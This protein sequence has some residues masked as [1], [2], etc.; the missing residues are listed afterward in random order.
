MRISKLASL[1]LISLAVVSQSSSAQRRAGRPVA[2]T[3]STLFEI[4]PYAGY[5]VFGDFLSGPLGT[6]LKNAPAPV[7]GAQLG[8]KIAP[9]LSMIGN[10]AASTS[11]IRIG[12]PF[13][14]GIDVAHSS[15]VLYDAGL[16]LDIPMT[17]AYGYTFAPFV[18]GGVG[19]MHYDITQ[20]LVSTSA[21]NLAG[22]IG[23]GADV[24]IGRGVGLRLMAKDYIGKFNF[25]DATSFDFNGET[26]HNY[27]LSAGL[28]FSF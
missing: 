15:M 17:N 3:T 8:M 25:Q 22:N 10:L 14:G 11:D 6:S 4:T 26:T 1:A 9:N 23:V 24:A 16:Q 20:S 19:A 18:Q 7:F 12:V 27:T 28:R 2:A 13:I 21:T 5:M